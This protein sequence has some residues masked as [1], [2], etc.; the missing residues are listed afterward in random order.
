MDFCRC[1]TS[2]ST[3]QKLEA[4]LLLAM[5]PVEVAFWIA[6]ALPS[7]HSALQAS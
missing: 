7:P 5:L 2:F 6:F 1:T 3:G 4:I